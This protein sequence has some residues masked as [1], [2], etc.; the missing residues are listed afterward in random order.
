MRAIYY[1]RIDPG[2]VEGYIRGIYE[3][4]VVGRVWCCAIEPSDPW[5][6]N[7]HTLPWGIG[8]RRRGGWITT[9]AQRGA[10]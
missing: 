4:C 9:I 6:I 5:G 2:E 3:G 8:P 1:D 10:S 7:R